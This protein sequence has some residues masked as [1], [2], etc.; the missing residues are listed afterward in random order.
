MDIIHFYLCLCIPVYIYKEMLSFC[1]SLENNKNEP[2][3]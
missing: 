3:I 2:S 1:S